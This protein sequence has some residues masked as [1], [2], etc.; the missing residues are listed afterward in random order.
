MVVDAEFRVDGTAAYML[1]IGG[2]YGCILLW[3]CS[4]AAQHLWPGNCRFWC[5]ASTVNAKGGGRGV[6]EELER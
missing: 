4:H 2:A 6:N 3:R 1:R 5:Y